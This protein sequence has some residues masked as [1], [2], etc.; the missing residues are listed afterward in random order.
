[1]EKVKLTFVFIFSQNQLGLWAYFYFSRPGPS[2]IIR[3]TLSSLSP[4][5]FLAPTLSSLAP[6]THLYRTDAP[7]LWS[8]QPATS[9]TA[10]PSEF[11]SSSSFDTSKRVWIPL[12][13]EANP[14][15]S[16]LGSSNWL[17][18]LRLLPHPVLLSCN[19]QL[20]CT[21]STPH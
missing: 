8:F 9:T 18:L 13:A 4:V 20:P 15:P 17:R 3:L 16:S 14:N 5:T 2:N 21:P 19:A 12:S 11:L 10:T 7:P 6:A 1:M